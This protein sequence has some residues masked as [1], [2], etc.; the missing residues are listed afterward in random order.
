MTELEQDRLNYL[1]EGM[2]LAA[3][4]LDGFPS[5]EAQHEVVTASGAEEGDEL[6]AVIEPLMH[7]WPEHT[8]EL[9]VGLSFLLGDSIVRASEGLAEAAAQPAEAL[10][11]GGVAGHMF[12]S[13]D[14][15]AREGI[16]YAETL[17]VLLGWA[18]PG[19]LV[20][21]TAE[22]P[23]KLQ[24]HELSRGGWYLLAQMRHQI[25]VEYELRQMAALDPLQAK[26]VVAAAWTMVALAAHMHG[27]VFATTE[28]RMHLSAVTAGS[29]TMSMGQGAETITMF[30]PSSVRSVVRL[31]REALQ[32]DVLD[33]CDMMWLAAGMARVLIHSSG[34]GEPETGGPGYG[35]FLSHRGRDVKA[36]LTRAVLSLGVRPA[37]FLDC[38]SLPRGLINRHF[39]FRSLVRSRAVVV[40]D[41]PNFDESAWC[42][43]E[44]WV[45]EALA[46]LGLAQLVR[47]GGAGQAA[48]LLEDES[49]TGRLSPPPP[50]AVA[51]G[52]PAE[53]EDDPTAWVCNRILNDI[54]YWART[55]NLH[56]AREKKL[57]IGCVQPMLDWLRTEC[58]AGT[59]DTAALRT[60]LIGHV[61]T[62]L[63]QLAADVSRWQATQP[64]SGP[65][66]PG[67]AAD[68]WA[69][70]A[71]LTVAALSL[72][73]RTY[74]KME[75]RRYVVAVNRLTYEILDAVRRDPAADPARLPDCILLAAGA[76]ALDLAGEDRPAVM[77]IGLADLVNGR[78]LCQDVLLMLDVR[79]PGPRRD[80]LL[81]LVLLLVANDV[82]SVGVLQDGTDPV[83]DRTI[84]GTSLEVLPCVT[85]YPGMESLFAGLPA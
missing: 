37:V 14:A 78:A 71:Q 81:R 4:V 25:K 31:L 41:S 10:P 17:S 43:K 45:A 67:P 42:R 48:R 11:A 29:V 75:T 33:A 79:R 23:G 12:G 9:F 73:T 70:A 3:R 26:A 69:T 28:G 36:D 49:R 52:A 83:H 72:R 27:A 16:P 61:R 15:A 54:D 64:A 56:S 74:S 63:S 84:D 21:P 51:A 8:F 20:K 53:N 24:P 1:L 60:A 7:L 65:D 77:E 50:V 22:G 58:R 39:V 30:W 19:L 32:S 6:K 18:A 46:R 85:L 55:P 38:L 80:F 76:V 2:D 59:T 44:A 13:E 68:L 66:G 34:W 5:F 82:G 40:V 62:M 35:L 57:P 47:V